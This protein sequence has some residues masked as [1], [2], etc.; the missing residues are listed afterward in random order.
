MRWIK[1]TLAASGVLLLLLATALLVYR[2]RVLPQTS[3]VIELKASSPVTG[4]TPGA[5]IRIERDA[6]GIPTIRAQSLADTCFGLGVVHAQDRLWQLETH[7]RIGAGRLAEA[8]GPGALPTDRFL[9]SLGVRRMAQAQ[10]EHLPE[11]SRLL[12]RAYAAGVNSVIH[13]QLRARPPEF[14]ILGLQPEDWDPVDSL[15]WAIMM[16][17][18]LGGNWNSELLRLRLALKLPVARINELM[19]PA[20]GEHSVA[21]ADYAALYRGLGLGEPAR[22]TAWAGLVDSAPPSGIEGEGSNNW[23]LAG[24]RTTTGHPLLANDPHLKLSTPALWYFA[25]LEAPGFSVAG[26]SLP[27]LPGIVLGQNAHVAWGFTNTGP[28]VQDLYLEQVDPARPGRYRT[29][30]G[31]ADFETA[32]EVIKVRGQPDV[33]MT[34]RRSRHGPVISDAGP[35]GGGDLVGAPGKPGYVLALRWTALDPDVDPIAPDLAMLKSASVAGFFAATRGWVAPMQNMVVADDAGHIGLIAPGRVP[36]RKAENDLGG[37]APAPGWDARYDWDGWIPTDATPRL[38]DPPGGA[39]ATANQ[40]VTPA[41]YPYYLTNEWALPY[42][43][44]RIVQ[45]LAAKPRHSLDDLAAIQADQVSLAARKLLPWLLEA[46]SPHPLAAAAQA[47]LNGFDGTMAADKAAPLVY[48]AWQRQLARGLFEP[49]VGPQL[50][51]RGLASR[52]FQDALEGVLER[53]DPY[54]CEASK[55][56]AREACMDQVDAAFTRALD[57][58]Q[59]GWGSDPDRWRWGRAHPMRAEHRPFSHVAALA[60][61]FELRAPVGGD[62]FT[63][64]AA[65][66]NLVPD[67]TTGELFLDEHGPSLRALYDLG[68]RRNSRVVDSSG[69]RGIVLSPLY[70]NLLPSWLR[71]QGVPLWPAAAPEQVL[72]L[73][74][75]H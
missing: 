7:R 5:E 23:V 10:W 73:R 39:I 26:A 11:S 20:P 3:G 38:V 32:T 33:T 41:G 75:P 25:R 70:R 18:D 34:V 67:A 58:L 24:S 6:D 54:W 40:R 61:W 29:P 15:A 49:K 50:W 31:W 45:L 21:R 47:E 27:G 43:H 8:F 52:S 48:W 71:V 64:N 51:E 72:V 1:R 36:L 16:A 2:E 12:L 9:R 13:D 4:Y 35:G 59:Q 53:N 14:L 19:P 37:E 56:R 30:D 68:D 62:T 69:Q 44:E 65:R 57:E 74:P 22:L 17:W 28:D 46:R 55:A 42:R 60:P 66:V 63:V